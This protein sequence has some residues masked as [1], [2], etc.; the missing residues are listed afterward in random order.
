MDDVA[1]VFKC[2]EKNGTILPVFK[3]PVIIGRRPGT[4]ASVKPI[5]RLTDNLDID[6]KQDVNSSADDNVKKENDVVIKNSTKKL[7]LEDKI[8]SNKSTL[9]SAQSCNLNYVAPSTSSICQLPYQLEVLKD[10]VI[11]QSENLQFK[12][13]PFYVFGRLPTCDF[14]LQHPS[15][16]RY[17]T[18]LQYKIDDERGDSGWFL[19]DLG[20]THGTFLN[21]QQIPPKV[22]CRLH[23]GHVFKFGVS[24]RLFILQ[25]P[26]EDQEAV[27]ELSVTQL[28]EMKLKRELSIDKLDNQHSFNDKCGVSTASVPPSTSSGINWGMR[29]DAEDENPLAENPFALADDFQLDETL[30]LDDPKKTL[31]GWFEREGYELEY[32][33]E[34][35]NYAHFI[36]RVEL[37]IDSASGA[38]IVAEASVKGG[39]KKEAVVQCALEACRL[40][41]RHGMLRQSKHESKSRRKKRNFDDDYYSSDEDTFLD[42]TGTVER[43]RQARMKEQ[44]SD[45]VETYESLSLK[46]K[47]VLKEVADIQHTLTR[48]TAAT[49][50]PAKIDIDDVDAYMEALQSYESSN[51]KSAATLRLKLGELQREETRLKALLKIAR[52][53]VLSSSEILSVNTVTE[54]RVES[55]L[56]VLS[57]EKLEREVDSEKSVSSEPV[58]TV[59]VVSVISSEDGIPG[60]D[61]SKKHLPNLKEETL[62]EAPT[63]EVD[64][65]SEGKS[66][67]EKIGLVIRK[68]RKKDLKKVESVKS[69]ANTSSNSYITD[70][71]KYAM[72]TPPENQ[73]GDG[74]TSLNRKY[75][76]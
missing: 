43:K 71:S 40:L 21:K 11:I 37:P 7:E 14:V 15:I 52:P 55:K 50:N 76:Y 46:Y 66:N 18:V 27:S 58:L 16:S 1:E 25:G 51:K 68:K 47:D 23:T 36:C 56:K 2:T 60:S 64:Q 8:S 29:E 70:D 5:N 63:C 69:T 34:E 28:K 44:T 13:K 10:G 61:V 30:Y 6:S 35:K 19:F 54:S 65:F 62:L 31:R 20:S 41:D 38:P 32:K 45:V 72:W 57:Q 3:K 17:H 53:A 42:R 67:N 74:K 4:K 59:P 33:V 9:V 24:S 22:Y 73:S 12:Q 26:E 49:R 48:M 39:K 75:G